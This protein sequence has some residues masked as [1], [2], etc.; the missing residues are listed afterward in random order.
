MIGLCALFGYMVAK[1]LMAA[2]ETGSRV[3]P[4]NVFG[5]GIGGCAL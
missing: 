3:E 2:K 4:K 5:A 1:F